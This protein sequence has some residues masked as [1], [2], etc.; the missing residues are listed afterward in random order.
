MAKKS[1]E[2]KAETKGGKITI[3]QLAEE[4]G[5]RPQ[6]LRALIREAGFKAPATGV[7]GFGPKAKYE[8][9]EGSAEL[10]KVRKAIEATLSEE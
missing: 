3:A 6:K 10:N 8:W 9:D 5:M 2:A 1:K 4:Y 7:Q